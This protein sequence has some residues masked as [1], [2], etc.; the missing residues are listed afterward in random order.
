MIRPY[1]WLGQPCGCTTTIQWLAATGEAYPPEL[2]NEIQ[3]RLDEIKLS[4]P[5]KRLQPPPPPKPTRW[6]EKC[7]EKLSAQASQEPAAQ[8]S[9]QQ[10][11]DYERQ[12]IELQAA[13]ALIGQRTAAASRLVSKQSK[14]ST[15]PSVPSPLTTGE[16]NTT[17]QPVTSQEPATAPQS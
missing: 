12:Y 1:H 3:P 13:F 8:P 5:A 7:K 11:A 16:A 9:P 17:L 15:E 10:L 2:R 4:R 6:Q 14:E